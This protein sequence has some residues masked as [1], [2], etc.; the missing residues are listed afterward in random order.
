MI[1]FGDYVAVSLF[2]C[3]SHRYPNRVVQ[4]WAWN[5]QLSWRRW[6]LGDSLEGDLVTI[7]ILFSIRLIQILPTNTILHWAGRRSTNHGKARSYNLFSSSKWPWQ[8]YQT[9]LSACPLVCCDHA[10][11]PDC[12]HIFWKDFD[13]LL[14]Q[15]TQNCPSKSLWHLCLQKTLTKTTERDSGLQCCRLQCKTGRNAKV[16][17]GVPHGHTQK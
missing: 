7:C 3:V 12:M 15:L 1:A 2:C 5:C 4:K 8:N 17:I 10:S 6:S 13:Q 16:F 9:I 14:S 11:V